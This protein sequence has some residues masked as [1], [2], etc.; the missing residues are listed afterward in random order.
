MALT[1][2]AHIREQLE[3]EAD[4]VEEELGAA[5]ALYVEASYPFDPLPF[6]AWIRPPK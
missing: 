6:E 4:L 2:H 1:P 3:E 5:Y